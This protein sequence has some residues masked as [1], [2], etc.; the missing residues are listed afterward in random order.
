M[1]SLCDTEGSIAAQ[2]RCAL[3]R[4]G[5]S[6]AFRVLP[7]QATLPSPRHS[8]HVSAPLP[9]PSPT[10]LIPSPLRPSRAN[11]GLF[12]IHTLCFE[13]TAT[14]VR[15]RDSD[16]VYEIRVYM[17]HLNHRFPRPRQS[18]TIT[19]STAPTLA[20]PRTPFTVRESR[21]E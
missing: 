3:V 11:F 21:N 14:R 10:H 1:A 2:L 5:G 4:E 12:P 13:V 8:A 18:D 17:L 19:H 20:S 9:T 6:V 16:P 15:H 7:T